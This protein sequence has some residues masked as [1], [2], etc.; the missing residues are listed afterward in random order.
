MRNPRSAAPP[1]TQMSTRETPANAGCS[2]PP[3]TVPSTEGA[4]ATTAS[5]STVSRFP[6]P[7]LLYPPHSA[8][9][10]RAAPDPAPKCG[11]LAVRP[12]W[13]RSAGDESHGSWPTCTPTVLCWL[14]G[15]GHHSKT[16]PNQPSPN[17][18]SGTRE[19]HH[20]RIEDSRPATQSREQPTTARVMIFRWLATPPI[21]V[22]RQEHRPTTPPKS[23]DP[24]L[25]NTSRSAGGGGW[26]APSTGNTPG[27]TADRW[28]AAAALRM[29]APPT[30]QPRTSCGIVC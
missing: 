27:S 21:T 15:C 18:S 9:Q 24:Y 17:S 16:S 29:A 23:A 10:L 25:G 3:R 20:V 13:R 7:D 6:F 26:Q 19:N 12:S 22:E 1:K 4:H 28:R 11:F 8:A 2:R 30:Q 5:K 14:L